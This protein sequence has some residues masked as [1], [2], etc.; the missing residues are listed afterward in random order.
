MLIPR[1]HRI[2]MCIGLSLMDAA[3]FAPLFVV[4]WPF[5]GL[6]LLL[7]FG[8]LLVAL[9]TGVVLL[10]GVRSLHLAPLFSYPIVSLLAFT[11]VVL[12]IYGIVYRPVP[13]L[14]PAW[15]N[16]TYR[17]LSPLSLVPKTELVLLITGFL[18]WLRAGRLVGRE[19]EISSISLSFRLGLLTL[20]TFG[21]LFRSLS[22]HSDLL[23][24]VW[25]YIGG[26]LMSLALARSYEVPFRFYKQA[27]A[28]AFGRLIQLLAVV[29]ATVGIGF[30]CWQ[31]LPVAFIPLLRHLF[32]P[33]GKVLIFVFQ[34]VLLIVF[35]VAL[36][37]IQLA[38][39]LF[40]RL[41]LPALQGVE[42]VL[43]VAREL[44][45][46]LLGV[47]GALL[48]PPP[49]LLVLIEAGLIG[50]VVFMSVRVLLTVLALVRG[51]PPQESA[52]ES[53]LD[54]ALDGDMLR[55]GLAQLRSLADLLQRYGL[56]QQLLAAISVKNI[57]ANLSRL[58]R[59]RGYPRKSSQPP[60]AYL[61]ILVEAF[62]GYG[63]PLA[64]ITEAYMAVHYG[65][66]LIAREELRQLRRDYDT[67]RQGCDVD[68]KTT[69]V[70]S[71]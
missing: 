20:I 10:S 48:D 64:R 29:L 47:T 33:V 35:F 57:Y 56:S 3:W 27:P 25:L 11:S 5:E 19:F 34:V 4:L 69:K 62:E 39:A 41:P 9:L 45:A 49:W 18:V 68:P 17:N 50:I 24:L 70:Y 42:Y 65:D 60:D 46:A 31:L 43:Q 15:L 8:W 53:R 37:I 32:N 67:I 21:S 23:L 54:V 38:R 52:V 36:D 28:L 1:Q 59:R 26:G 14:S 30:L 63:E 16:T 7:A 12:V 58:A 6:R 22:L 13:L 71:G 44:L 40:M 51:V 66:R 2:L 61:P 55:R